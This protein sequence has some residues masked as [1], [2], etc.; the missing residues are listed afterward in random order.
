MTSLSVPLRAGFSEVEEPYD[1]DLNARA[2]LDAAFE[3]ARISRTRVLAKF[4]AAWCPDCRILAGMMASP[5]IASFL[6]RRFEV[7][8]IHIGR[9]DANMDLVEQLGLQAGLEGVPAVVIAKADGT[10]V[11]TPRIF[12]WRTARTRSLQDLAD[13][14]TAF[15]G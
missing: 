10:V 3:R 5:V 9:Y 2:A 4:G 7:V 8:P 6:E 15:A 12:E 11:N 14:L 1:P 13:Y